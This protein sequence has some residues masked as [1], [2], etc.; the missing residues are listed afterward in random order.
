MIIQSK[1]GF[2]LTEALVTTSVLTIIFSAF[3][4][5]LLSSSDS[6]QTNRV[7]IELR[8]ELRKSMD[9]IT[10]DILQAGV[11][12][13]TDVS[14]NGSWYTTITFKKPSSISGGSVVWD[15]NTTKFLRSSNELQRQIGSAAG[16]TIASNITTL[17][18]RRQSDT[19]SVV[20]VN[21]Q[22]QKST[23]KGTVIADALSFKIRLR[24]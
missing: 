5:V 6:W 24:N 18:F 2:T 8:Q 16:E 12:T 13:I 17:Q 9:S 7:S 22:A 19:P 3:F 11:S 4:I 23:P 21:L 1:K 14:A 15:A 20:E 10:R